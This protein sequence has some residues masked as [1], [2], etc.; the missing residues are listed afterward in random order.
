MSNKEKKSRVSGGRAPS[1]DRAETSSIESNMGRLRDA[2]L[3]G[4]RQAGHGKVEAQVEIDGTAFR[5]NLALELPG[6]LGQ[7]VELENFVCASFETSLDRSGYMY[8]RSQEYP[9]PLAIRVQEEGETLSLIVE[10][11]QTY[12]FR[13][14]ARVDAEVLEAFAQEGGV[15]AEAV[16]LVAKVVGELLLEME[17]YSPRKAG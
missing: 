6:I 7:R 1:E 5:G 17:D 8:I 13:P 14:E 4:V 10:S 3:A 2:F 15:A 11:V 16:L 12:K 9:H